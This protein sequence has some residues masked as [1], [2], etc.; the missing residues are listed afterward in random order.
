MLMP[1]DMPLDAGV[2]CKCTRC[3]D[4]VT[5]MS[6]TYN[7]NVRCYP[8]RIVKQ[9][10]ESVRELGL[11]VKVRVLRDAFLRSARARL[12]RMLLSLAVQA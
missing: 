10:R 8:K 7:A 6:C 4:E 9:D 5:G 3:N 2:W 11:C 1:V 12:R